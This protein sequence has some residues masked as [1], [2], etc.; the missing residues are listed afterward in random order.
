MTLGFYLASW[1]MLRG[2]SFL[3]G[4]SAKYYVPLIEYVAGLDE[5][6]WEIDADTLR[7]NIS[8]VLAIYGQIKSLTV[9]GNNSHLTLV[10]KIML[11]VFGFIP[12]YDL[13]FCNTFRKIFGESHGFRSVNKRSLGAICDFYEDNKTEIDFAA[14]S[15]FTR[16]FLTG[17]LTAHNYPKS[18]IIDMYGFTAGIGQTQHAQP[19]E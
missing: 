5:K 18:K 11:G 17:Q 10:T 6:I 14:A 8:D 12:A 4:K 2:S 13:Y 19:A 15:L 16:D 1:G 7:D 9:K 3:L